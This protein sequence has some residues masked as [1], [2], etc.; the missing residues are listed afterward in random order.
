MYSLIEDFKIYETEKTKLVIIDGCAVSEDGSYPL[1][2]LMADEEELSFVMVRLQD[3]DFIQKHHL[4]A[5]SSM[6]GFR[7]IAR[8]AGSFNKLI[9]EADGQ[10]ILRVEEK[11]I[12]DNTISSGIVFYV[13]HTYM[14]ENGLAAVSGWAFSVEDEEIRY[15][16]A[17]NNEEILCKVQTYPRIDQPV[18]SGSDRENHY[19]FRISFQA[20]GGETIHFMTDQYHE[21][22]VFRTAGAIRE[23]DS[24]LARM[25]KKVNTKSMERLK[26]YYRQNGLLK[27]VN[28]VISTARGI[29]AYHQWFMEQKTPEKEL[30]RQREDHFAY[31]PLISVVVPTFNTPEK[32]LHEMIGSLLEQTYAN[33]QLCIAD[34]SDPQGRT[35]ELLRGYAEKDSRIKVTYLDR[36]YG[37]SGNTNKALELADGEYTGL[38]D[39]D[40]LL[41]PDCLYEITKALNQVRYDVIY[42]DEDKLNSHSGR[43]EAP[44]LK[45]DFDLF[46][47]RSENY[48]THFFVARTQLIRNSGGFHSEYDGSQDFDLTL[49]C[50][51]QAEQIC[52]IP[53][54]LY[55]WRMHGSS[56]AEDPTSKLYCYES[57]EKALHDHF[58]R[59]NIE[60]DVAFARDP[61]WGTYR[62][63]YHAEEPAITAVLRNYDSIERMQ[64]VMDML[65]KECGCNHFFFAGAADPDLPDAAFVED[66]ANPGKIL[67]S[68][69]RQTEDEYILFLDGV[70]AVS[71]D[72]VRYMAGACAQENVAA[73]SAMV[74]GGDGMIKNSGLI[75]G[76]GCYTDAFRGMTKNGPGIF[77]RAVVSCCFSAVSPQCVMIRRR[78]IELSGGFDEAYESEAGFVDWCLRVSAAGRKIV[79]DPYAIWSDSDFE[80]KNSLTAN[81]SVRL[82]EKHTY[83]FTGCDPY[84][85]PGYDPEGSLFSLR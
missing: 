26:R 56:T 79:Y 48:I 76:P 4:P 78:E 63:I 3:V 25:A 70:S 1:L 7:L 17:R 58:A 41:E 71:D 5:G 10:Q 8:T 21:T 18:I 68:V 83:I 40:D 85:N 6:C 43:F 60:A 29:D 66:N 16:A 57:G 33:W 20:Q 82:E 15:S 35:R 39:H 46:L 52:H 45:P 28:K 30:A 14:D 47:I 64:S 59:M 73:V 74:L 67:N 65:K 80:D 22:F 11:K 38:F 53:K 50:I 19:G 44:C 23:N 24:S 55:H 2:K 49:R 42:T 13:D 84:Y 72:A 75:I 37:I 69:S 34:G 62:V 36:N 27:T 9:L 61:L 31:E 12:R 77:N 51:E 54:V 32:Y 81:D